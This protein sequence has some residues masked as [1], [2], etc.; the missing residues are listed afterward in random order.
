MSSSL[1]TQPDSP[2]NDLDVMLESV[3]LGESSNFR[4]TSNPWTGAPPPPPPPPLPPLGSRDLISPRP[5]LP[6]WSTAGPPP[7]PPPPALPP[8]SQ[9]EQRQVQ[10]LPRHPPVYLCSIGGGSTPPLR[11]IRSTLQPN[12][13][14]KL[15]KNGWGSMPPPPPPPPI[16]G[17]FSVAPPLS[18]PYTPLRRLVQSPGFDGPPPPQAPTFPENYN[19]SISPKPK[20]TKGTFNFLGLP[21]EIR[22]EIYNLIL[23]REPPPIITP[24]RRSYPQTYKQISI[25]SSLFRVNRQIH[26]EATEWFYGKNTFVIRL[27]TDIHK[28]K[29]SVQYNTPWES[30][31]YS[32]TDGICLTAP[33]IE[34]EYDGHY[35][36]LPQDPMSQRLGL[37]D[38]YWPLIRNIRLDI[39]DFREHRYFVLP[40]S[41]IGLRSQKKTRNS[42]LLPLF[43]RLRPLLEAAGRDLRLYINIVSGTASVAKRVAVG[44]NGTTADMVAA[45]AQYTSSELLLRT[46]YEDMLRMA[47]PFTTGPWQHS[48]TVPTLLGIWREEIQNSVLEDCNMSH[49]LSEAEIERFRLFEEGHISQNY[50]WVRRQG[51]LLVLNRYLY[52]ASGRGKRSAAILERAGFIRSGLSQYFGEGTLDLMPD[53]SPDLAFLDGDIYGPENIEEWR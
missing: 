40:P 30:V 51:R 44:F 19:E 53:R 13:L 14:A 6:G 16:H 27:S 18:Q 32:F 39:E 52:N 43:H 41:I 42:I 10:P 5:P 26:Y 33:V 25:A 11:P 38:N 49:G 23:S 3:R 20:C 50:L 12:D 1:G 45:G 31:A 9:N 21:R 22:D 28:N 35:D 17:L 36:S 4:P 48:I 7:P 37:S 2:D 15:R 46:F 47:W 8:I 24:G 29:I 34:S